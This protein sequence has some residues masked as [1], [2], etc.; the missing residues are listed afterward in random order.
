MAGTFTYALYPFPW[1]A[2]AR[3]HEPPAGSACVLDFRPLTEQAKASQS[4]G[5][6]LFAWSSGA[7]GDAVSLGTGYAPELV[8][9]TA[10]R[11]ELRIKLGL[12]ANP[13]GATLADAIADVLGSLADPTGASGPKPVM[14]TS[15]GTLE[16]HL[17]GHSRIWSAPL[18]IAELLSA[19]PK[20]HANK[21]RDVI[22]AD[23]DTAEAIGGVSLLQKALGAKLLGLGFTRDEVKQG[24][25][26]KKSQWDR[27]LSA[28]VK[29]KHGANAKPAEPQTSFSESWPTSG[30]IRSGGQN[31]SW[32]CL[33]TANWDVYANSVGGTVRCQAG[34]PGYWYNGRCTSAVS[35]ADHWVNAV[36]VVQTAYSAGPACRMASGAA[37]CYTFQA[38]QFTGVRRLAK[39]VADTETILSSAA[40]SF[41][42][43]GETWRV[44]ANG[45]TISGLVGGST[46][47]SVTDTSVTGNLYGGFL[48][49]ES[50]TPAGALSVGAWSIDDGLSAGGASK[51]ILTLGVG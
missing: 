3:C 16:I 27:L 11:N 13:S 39:F 35:S 18:D 48:L 17:D 34:G 14:P 40:Y 22:R 33:D 45:S 23:L 1:N 32:A 4:S 44:R 19:N 12:S 49:S 42:F 5:F 43:S 47:E 20:G 8:I 7:P 25:S 36:L 6:G 2:V 41:P 24:A 38:R 50:G 21:I 26:G 37:T 46:L 10:A 51:N 9:D 15:D 28:A 31:Q 30:D 29:A